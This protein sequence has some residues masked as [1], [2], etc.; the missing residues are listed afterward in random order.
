MSWI[1]I[2]TN[3]KV[4]NQVEQITAIMNV[5]MSCNGKKSLS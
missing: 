5:I 4:L 3:E 2:G 1:D